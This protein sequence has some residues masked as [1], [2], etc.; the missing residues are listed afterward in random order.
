MTATTSDPP[1]M[2]RRLKLLGTILITLSAVTPASS[3]FIIAPGVMS[4]AGTGA[5]WAYIIA[6]LVGVCMAFVYAELASA[7]PLTGGEYTMTGRTVGRGAGFVILLLLVFTQLFIIAVIALGVGTYLGV[8]IPGLPG[9]ATGA[10]VTILAAGCG[11]LNVRVNAW[12][13]GVFLAVEMLALAVL[14]GLGLA[15]VHRGVGTLLT[16]PV[17]MGGGGALGPITFGAIAMATSVA[18]FSYNGY[19][20]AVYL[21]EET[22]QAHSRMGRAV[23]WSLLIT[24]IAEAVPLLTVLLGAPDL[25]ALFTSD[26]P[27][28]LFVSKLG[29]HGLDTALSLGVALAIINAVLAIVLISA[30]L[31]FSTGRDNTW[32][33][34][35]SKALAQV[36]PKLNS[37]WVATLITGV[38][39]AAA[40]FID[41]HL[42]LVMTGTSIVVV[43]AALCVAVIAGRRNGSTSHTHYRMPLFPL[44]P[45]LALLALVYVVYA[46]AKDPSVGRPSLY[47]TVGI[48]A[49]AV[50]YYA[51]VLRRRAGGWVLTEPDDYEPGGRPAP[52][53]LD[54]VG[55]LDPQA[56]PGVE[57]KPETGPESL[58]T[59]S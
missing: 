8:L 3:V 54:G 39:A 23:L 11:I 57:H 40:C 33:K 9:P 58:P 2:R 25:K 17:G 20:S 51:F 28:S 34:P 59:T 4:Q 15:N 18:I 49:V 45:I 47:V 53:L 12:L 35:I 36:H 46:N 38:L 5:L 55:E 29:G 6:A 50:L 16:H 21:G 27:M 30:R 22:E 56:I 43:Y 1:V 26:N 14:V 10:V 13:T 19:G 37:P 42:L 48:M 24:V 32:P 41:N 31:M 7:F 52:G 44:P